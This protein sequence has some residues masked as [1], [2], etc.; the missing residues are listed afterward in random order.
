MI[1]LAFQVS[2][3]L[4]ILNYY[5]FS[6]SVILLNGRVS[7]HI[8]LSNGCTQHT[9][10]LRITEHMKQLILTISLLMTMRGKI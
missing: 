6:F 3:S 4:S 2:P 7:S 5:H 1:C 9:E 8:L 10:L